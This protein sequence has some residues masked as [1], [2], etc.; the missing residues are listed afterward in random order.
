SRWPEKMLFWSERRALRG[1]LA[2]QCG[3]GL[4]DDGLEGGLVRHCEVSQYFAVELAAAGG[5]TLDKSAVGDAVCTAGGV[6]TRDPEAAERAFA[7][8][9]VAVRPVFR[10]HDRVFRVAEQLGPASPEAFGFVE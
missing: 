10:F 2:L 9:P 1:F 8:L 3:D 7:V 6:Q 5:E 4:L